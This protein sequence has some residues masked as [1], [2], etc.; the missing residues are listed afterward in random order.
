M[1]F[2]D[3]VRRTVEVWRS[4]SQW[5]NQKSG[6]ITSGARDLAEKADIAVRAR[7][8]PEPVKVPA[9]SQQ[10]RPFGKEGAEDVKHIV[11]T[12]HTVK[13]ASG[14][15]FY[16][17][18]GVMVNGYYRAAEVQAYGAGQERW[19]WLAERHARQDDAVLAAQKKVRA[20]FRG[21]IGSDMKRAVQSRRNA[22]ERYASPETRDLHEQVPTLKRR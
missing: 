1:G 18:V 2:K 11:W 9:Q 5:V 7:M 10:A 15:C 19:N 14:Q 13:N 8:E 4:A 22:A 17:A 6:A 16:G 21:D 12:G 3:R 20:S